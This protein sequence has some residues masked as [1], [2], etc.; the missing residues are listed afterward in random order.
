[1]ATAGRTGGAK[2][3][4]RPR[5]RAAARRAAAVHVEYHLLLMLA[6]GLVAFGLIMVYSASSG[7]TLVLGGDPLEPLLRQG[8]YAVVGVVAMV[9]AARLPT[10]RLRPL[11]PVLVLAALALL[12]AVMVPGVGAEIN[13]ARRWILLGP[14]SIQPSELA[15]LAVLLFA[16]AV[17]SARRRPPRGP[18]ELLNP[19][20]A[21]AVLV[22]A[23][24]VLEPD[25]G[26]AIAVALMVGGMFVVAGA[27]VALLAGAGILSLSA[28]AA[29]IYAE[30]YRRA[31]LFAFLDP[32]RDAA[33]DGYQNVQALIALGSG[34]L[35]GVGLGNGTQKIT[36]LPEAPTDMIV[37]VIGE[38]L[39]LLGTIGTVLAFAA[40]GVLGFRVAIRAPD[41]F[42]RLLAA[43]ITCLVCG[44]AV[45]NFGAVLGV[46]P[47]TGVPL[48]LISSGGS[49]LV[50]FL[51]MV[52]IL[53]RIADDGRAVASAVP[54][55][56]LADDD[57]ADNR[58]RP[59]PGARPRGRGRDGGTRRAGARGRRRAVG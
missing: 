52:G 5:A 35:W 50:V 9:I 39:G 16:A 6:L 40:F 18:I 14:F 51:A 36:Y 11:A 55:L 1:V 3:T 20:G 2:G 47:L 29:A 28:A 33:G 17:L 27:P 42:G 10:R 48:P 22:C 49:S 25:L 4:P 44:Q 41:A 38:E 43:G 32:W 12:V 46:L 57:L 8:A 15:K 21:L 19:V 45:V 56:R 59:E 54:A 30:P 7:T 58:K 31:R 26:T 24:V 23:L 53:L 13:G 34:G 37:A